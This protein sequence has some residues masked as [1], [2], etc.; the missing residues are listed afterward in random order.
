M[1][2]YVRQKKDNFNLDQQNLARD[3]LTPEEC[4]EAYDSRPRVKFVHHGQSS[5]DLSPKFKA[6]S[7]SIADTP[8]YQ[9]VTK[10]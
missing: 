2:D 8:Y 7:D 6:V 5:N 10:F 1:V 9:A 3:A 4:R